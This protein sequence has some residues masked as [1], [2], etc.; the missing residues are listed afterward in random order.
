MYI[1]LLFINFDGWEPNNDQFSPACGLD[2]SGRPKGFKRE[3]A[4]EQNLP[5]L[6]EKFNLV[7]K[8]TDTFQN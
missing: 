2:F 4:I 1:L 8:L 7:S 3:T 6:S 5:C